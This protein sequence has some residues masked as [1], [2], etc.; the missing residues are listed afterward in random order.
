MKK[1]THHDA[2]IIGGSYAGLSAAMALGRAIRNV[3]IIDNGKPCNRQTPHSHNFLTQDGNTPTGIASIGK[4]QVLNYPTVS[5][6]TDEA[7]MVNGENN[8]F[9][10]Y[11]TSGR[12][13]Y[14][15]KI[16]FATGITD[17][18]PD[19]KGFSECWGKSVIHCPYCHGYEFKGQ[20]TGILING[21]KAYEMGRLIHNWTDQ[22]TIFTNGESTIS[23]EHR[24]QLA[25]MKI[26]IDERPFQSLTHKEGYLDGI[27]F[28]NGDHVEIK[29][30][31]ARIPFEQHCAIPQELGCAM[32]DA[33]YIQ[34]DDF[35]KT[36]IP[37]IYAA[38]DNTTMLRAVSLAVA[39]GSKAA[40]VVNHELCAGH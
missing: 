30:L 33:G 35:Q 6:I 21:E 12:L 26:S 20:S 14:T 32:T 39:A 18:M 13:V 29:A 15:K 34:V 22:L 11:T 31:Y 1:E 36:T 10:V 37:G 5:F 40:S 24:Q 19:I 25:T 7:N 16:I 38:G 9:Q 23:D 2:V 8:L 27:I 17:T 4:S 28:S 3:L